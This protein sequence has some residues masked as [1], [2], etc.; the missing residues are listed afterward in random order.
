MWAYLSSCSHNSDSTRSRKR[1]T[2]RTSLVRQEDPS[3]TPGPWTALAAASRTALASGRASPESRAGR[4]RR[5]RRTQDRHPLDSCPYLRLSRRPLGF[6]GASRHR[7][8]PRA[9]RRRYCRRDILVVCLPCLQAAHLARRPLPKVCCRRRP[10]AAAACRLGRA[11]VL[12]PR[13]N[14]LPK[15][16][17]R[18]IQKVAV[19]LLVDRHHRRLPG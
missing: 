17:G 7:L 18:L 1:S 12:V 11:S 15:V 13:A 6:S 19:Y 8:R 9:Y 2:R 5:H 14:L 10:A 3:R 16:R 4:R